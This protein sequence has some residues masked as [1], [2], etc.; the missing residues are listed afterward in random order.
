MPLATPPVKPEMEP[1][2]ATDVLL[3]LQ[4]PL[5]DIS[6]SVVPAPAHT[7]DPPEIGLGNG[8][9]IISAVLMH[10]VTGNV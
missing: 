10:P 1:M 4:V 6:L 3:L 2:V 5:P 7:D 9:T 8:L